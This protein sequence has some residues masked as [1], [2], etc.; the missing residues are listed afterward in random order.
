MAD[1][2]ARILKRPRDRRANAASASADHH[3]TSARKIILRHRPHRHL[4][5]L[6]IALQDIIGFFVIIILHPM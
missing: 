4:P 3:S 5:V 6:E 2:R 1:L